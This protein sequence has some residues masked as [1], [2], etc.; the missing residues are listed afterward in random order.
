MVI[1]DRDMSVDHSRVYFPF[2]S[3]AY[4]FHL[5]FLMTH[6]KSH[7]EVNSTTLKDKEKLLLAALHL[8]Y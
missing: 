3:F 1:F 7:V 6:L 5:A 4:A 2:H 8:N